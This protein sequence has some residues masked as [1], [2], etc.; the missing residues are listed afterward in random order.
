MAGALHLG[1]H[2]QLAGE[3]YADVV[4]AIAL[5]LAAGRQDGAIRSDVD[6]EELLLLV[7][8]LWRIDNDVDWDTRSSHLLGLVMDALHTNITVDISSAPARRSP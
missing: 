1:T 8:F 5:L 6:A 4:S 2:E 3:G 7:G